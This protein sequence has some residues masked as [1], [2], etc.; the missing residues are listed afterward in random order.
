MLSSTLQ[1]TLKE[2]ETA[3]EED[4]SERTNVAALQGRL[5][6]LL[7]L[8][9]A[10][11]A[12]V[13]EAEYQ[14]HTLREALTEKEFIRS[15]ALQAHE[16]QAAQAEEVAGVAEAEVAAV[17]Q[18]LQEVQGLEAAAAKTLQELE[19]RQ[20]ALHARCDPLE[21]QRETQQQQIAERL[22]E[23]QQEEQRLIETQQGPKS[24][25]T[26]LEEFKA[27]A[28]TFRETIADLES[29]QHSLQHAA[30]MAGSGLSRLR[31]EAQKLQQQWGDMQWNIDKLQQ[32]ISHQN[33]ELADDTR[34]TA[35]TLHTLR[36]V[37]AEVQAT[38]SDLSER[39]REEALAIED[40]RH[41]TRENQL[42]HH[43]LRQH[44]MRSHQLQAASKEHEAQQLPMLQ[45]LRGCE[46]QR[47]SLLSACR[48]AVEERQRKEV[49]VEALNQQVE[50][51]CSELQELHQSL[52]QLQQNEE[53]AQSGFQRGDSELAV[54]RSRMSEAT[55]TLEMQEFASEEMK[56]ERSKLRLAASSQQLAINEA[57]LSAA[58][59]S[60]QAETL[61]SEV[62][63]LQQE[64]DQ[65]REQLSDERRRGEEAARKQQNLQN[66]LASQRQMQRQ[67]EA[68]RDLLRQ[69][70]A[71]PT[72]SVPSASDE[73]T[74]ALEHTLEDLA[75]L[76]SAMVQ[77]TYL[78]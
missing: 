40:L 13:V 4:Q 69:R 23:L 48:E 56:A 70:Q 58:S 33:G 61:R 17:R 77:E 34:N 10:R 63:K 74:A 67:K 3:R 30:D 76:E 38:T 66:L 25:R 78:V 16:A 5:K 14:L 2:V 35:S 52:E 51:Y 42:L 9:S 57:V 18:K 60:A 45:E 28:K 41:M 7:P 31:E 54:L 29:D 19:A 50:L 71:A 59:V 6:K 1:H 64:L 26:R 36:L 44:Q 53:A 47:E 49:A 15:E 43:E 8:Q 22:E 46:F 65:A 11:Q 32:S 27:E 75:Q 12:E 68:E 24:V 72:P 20:A 37:E 73:N 55:Q 62:Q 21:T 39:A